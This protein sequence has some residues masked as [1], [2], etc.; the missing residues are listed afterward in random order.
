MTTDNV[1]TAEDL[2]RN[3]LADLAL[4]QEKDLPAGPWYAHYPL[5]GSVEGG[6]LFYLSAHSISEDG[7]VVFAASCE[8]A[9]RGDWSTLEFI[10][11]SREGWPAA[12][13]RALAAEE[14][15]R[16]LEQEMA[17]LRAEMETEKKKPCHHDLAAL[18][19]NGLLDEN[20]EPREGW[21]GELR[22]FR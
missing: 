17:A 4:A 7:P 19:A 18:W 3:L 1:P 12:I 14:R 6:P 21:E 15:V 22:K 20:G 5:V 13:R 8:L 2:A 9:V 10:A 16:E 11:V